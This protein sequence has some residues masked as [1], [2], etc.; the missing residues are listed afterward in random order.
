MR[1][2][3]IFRKLRRTNPSDTAAQ[4]K[5]LL[6]TIRIIKLDNIW[7][8]ARN[9]VRQNKDKVREV[10]G[11]CKLL[12][13]EGPFEHEGPYPYK[14]HCGYETVAGMLLFSRRPGIISKDYMQFDTI[15]NLR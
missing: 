7:S 13:L 6:A 9:T 12:G 15:R 1:S 3:C 2:L 5:L 11:F 8:R 10:I 14:Y 4:E